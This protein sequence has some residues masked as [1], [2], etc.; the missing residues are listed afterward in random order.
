MGPEKG[1][2]LFASALLS[3]GMDEKSLK[4]LDNELLKV[5]IGVLGLP[6]YFPPTTRT[7][8]PTCNPRA[9]RA[10]VAS[11]TDIDS[12]ARNIKNLFKGLDSELSH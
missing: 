6:K 3:P 4:G 7:P 12:N 1:R 9:K 2:L 10:D 11:I 5:A 8:T